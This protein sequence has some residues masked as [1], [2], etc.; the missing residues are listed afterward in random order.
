MATC[1]LAPFPSDTITHYLARSSSI[2]Y[3]V[4]GL[5][6]IFVSFDIKRYMPLIKLLAC[7]RPATWPAPDCDRLANRHAMVVDR[8]RKPAFNDVGEVL[9]WG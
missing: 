8:H 7:H 5:L 9:F 2:M 3:A 6:L 4:H 1:D